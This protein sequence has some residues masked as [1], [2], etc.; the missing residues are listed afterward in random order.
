M[1]LSQIGQEQTLDKEKL[2]GIGVIQVTRL[3]DDSACCRTAFAR[4]TGVS[5]RNQ[6]ISSK[7]LAEIE[8]TFRK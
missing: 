2:L 5:H 7:A 4:R 1:P 6:E 3:G 8:I